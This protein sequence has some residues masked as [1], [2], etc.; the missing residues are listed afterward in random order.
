MYFL[1]T[2]GYYY[3]AIICLIIFKNCNHCA[4]RGDKW[5][6]SVHVPA[7]FHH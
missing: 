5:Y 7:V 2:F 4:F 6:Y 3:G 1:N